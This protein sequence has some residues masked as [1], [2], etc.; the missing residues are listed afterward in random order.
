[1]DNEI[2]NVNS[3]TQPI[4]TYDENQIQVLEGLEAVRRRPGMYIGSTDQRGLHHLVY[5][6]VDNSVDEALAGRCDTILITL[7][8]DNSATVEDN[9]HGIPCGMHPKLHKSAVEVCL[10]VLHAGGKF[11]GQ[12]YKVSGGLHGVGMSVVNALSKSLEVTVWQDGKVHEQSYING[13]PVEPLKVTGETEK[14]GTKI[15]FY[16]NGDIFET[17]DFDYDVLSKRFREMAFLNAGIRISIK[18]ER[19]GKEDTYHYE[20]GVKSFVEYLNRNKETLSPE[21]IYITGMKGD[22]TVEVALQYTDEYNESVYTFA[23]NINTHEGGTHLEGFR[24]ALTKSINDYA[25]KYKYLREN[26][27]NLQGEDIREGLTAIVSVKLVEPQ[28]EG[29]TKMKLGNSEMRQIVDNIVSD[30]LSAFLEENPSVSRTIIDKCMTAQR[31][32]DAARKARELT[33]RK[34]ALDSTALPGKLADC[35]EKDPSK[36][37]IFIVEGNSAGGSAKGGRDRNFQAIL[38]LRGKILNVEKTRLDRV[39]ANEEIKAMI[40]AFGAGIGEEFNPEKLRYHR[41]VCMTDADVDGSHIRILLLT[42]FYRYMRPLIE[43]G[44]V[45]IAQPPLYKVTKGK[46]N[47]RYFYNDAQLDAYMTEIGR[48][49]NDVKVQRYKGL[50]EMSAE[51]LWETTM[52]PERRIMLR[53][54]MEDAMIADETFTLLMGDNVEPRKAY[55]EQNAKTVDMAELDI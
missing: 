53:V 52:D 17:T 25:R 39:L 38:P 48:G 28:F 19:S 10:T 26:N 55:I 44:Y 50:G 36:C 42:F 20:G 34:T 4:N 12:G 46:N 24:R 47:V 16:P 3:E 35:S 14:H 30:G 27:V 9:G 5:E 6:L 37:E 51:Q 21:P 54:N 33:R 32:R 23:N 43:Q 45:Y 2:T 13:D 31:A 40:T 11:G 29:Q 1:M 15:R 18:D 41:I 22:S 49:S 7:H 8:E